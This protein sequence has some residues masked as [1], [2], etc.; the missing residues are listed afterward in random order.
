MRIRIS[1]L[2]LLFKVQTFKIKFHVF[3]YQGITDINAAAENL[4]QI[5]LDSAK[6]SLKVVNNHQNNSSTKRSGGLKR[7]KPL[8]HI[9]KQR[10]DIDLKAMRSKVIANGKLYSLFPKDPIVRG[11]YFKLYRTNNATK[12]VKER[13]YKKTVVGKI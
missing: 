12:R 7:R 8:K 3:L 11:R 4:N 2:N 10:F 1:N 5:L 9:S 13:Q 6:K